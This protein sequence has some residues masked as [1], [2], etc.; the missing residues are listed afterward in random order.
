MTEPA[1]GSD[2]SREFEGPPPASGPPTHG[3]GDGGSG[4]TGVLRGVGELLVTVGLLVLLFVFYEVY[5]TDWFS[6]GKQRNA[7]E[8]L[9]KQWSNNRGSGVGP[10]DGEAFARMYIPAL[11]SDYHFA[12][13][14]GI[15]QRA[16]E[17]GPGHY[18]Q[19]AM[20]GQAGNFAVAGHRVGRGAPFNDIDLVRPCDAIVVET[21][22]HWYVYRMLP[23]SG[24]AHGWASGPGAR[25]QCSRVQP[26]GG[27]YRNVSGQRIVQ[28]QQADVIN[29]IPGKQAKAASPRSKQ[30][31]LMTMTTCHPKF[32]ARKRLILH[33]V[34]VKTYEK[35][36]DAT[37][38][39]LAETN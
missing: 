2:G 29:P 37:P 25:K 11:G 3:S 8:R 34:L 18:K 32:S 31:A 5:V 28:P 24:Q 7:T 1:T 22:D 38:P 9:E 10:V 21:A 26:L 39:E 19:T 35:H 16:L 30:A 27:A 14:Q 17:V 4:G 23:K 36:G 15:G 20:P 12:I 13:M 6:A 33:G